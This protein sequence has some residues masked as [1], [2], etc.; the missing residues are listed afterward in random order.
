MTEISQS[1]RW[2]SSLLSTELLAHY[3]QLSQANFSVV[4]L[5]TTGSRPEKARAIEVSVLQASLAEGIQDQ[6]THLINPGVPIPEVI[7]RV[8]GITQAMVDQAIAPEKVWPQYHTRLNT[9]ILTAHNLAFDYRF[10]Q[11]E[12]ER[13]GQTFER[14]PDERLCTV[15]LSRLMLADLP[16]RSLPR[17]VEHFGFQVDESHRAAADTLACWYLA[18]YLLRQIQQEPEA[19][20]LRQFGQ[21]WMRLKDAAKLLQRPRSETQSLLEQAGAENR[22]SRSQKPLYRRRDVEQVFWSQQGQQLSL[23]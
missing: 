16:S 11:A 1:S 15:L 14:S 6:Q 23:L 20:I 8:T 4:D 12:Y 18:A 3:R 9:G 22:M 13:L 17:L 10:L 2:Q 21:Q 5:E 7:T 19:V